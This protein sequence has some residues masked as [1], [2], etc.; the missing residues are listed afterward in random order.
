MIQKIPG[1]DTRLIALLG[2]PLRQSFAARMQNAAYA[3]LG[4]DYWYFPVEIDQDKLKVVLD[5]LRE[6]NFAGFAVTKPNK[7][8]VLEYLDALDP[9]AERIGSVNTLVLR[10]GRLTGYNTDGIGW[11]QSLKEAFP[12]LSLPRSRFMLYGAGGAARAVATTLA[13][14]GVA[15]LYITDV[16]EAA[17]QSLVGDLNRFGDVARHV[18]FDAQ[19]HRLLGEVDVLVNASGIGMGAH[20]GESPVPATSLHPGLHVCDL[21]YNPAHTQLLLD[22]QARGCAGVLNG[23]EMSVIQGAKQVALWAPGTPEPVAIMREIVNGLL[24]G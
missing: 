17:A 4:L 24:A 13:S 15:C 2:T 12:H 9:L 10:D 21:A 6:M 22:A 18:P 5:G 16:V 19:P 20:L 23:L 11:V 1:V 3:R 14:E 7:I 8:K